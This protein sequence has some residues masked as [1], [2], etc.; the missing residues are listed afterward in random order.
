MSTLSVLRFSTA[1]GAR[2]MES[3]FLDLQ[4][5]QLIVVLDAALLTW[6]QGERSPKTKQLHTLAG[7]SALDE[8]FWGMLFGL[9]FFVP[10]FGSTISAA[11]SALGGKFSDYGVDRTFIKQARAT[12]TEGDSALFVLTNGTVQDK[13][14]AALNCP[15]FELISTNLPKEK[16]AELRATF[17]AVSHGGWAEVSVRK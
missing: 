6:P 11:I 8:T 4:E 1:D 7:A 3:A 13:V 14:V 16:E 17:G 5:R 15:S 2:Q 9:I 10:F 12:V